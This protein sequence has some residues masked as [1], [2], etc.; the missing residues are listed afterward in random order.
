MAWLFYI[1]LLV[2]ALLGVLVNIV[3]LP[4]LWLIVAAVAGY[5]WATGWNV[6]VGWP[7]LI[8]LIVLALCGELI[9]F[10]ATTRG[11]QKA[12]GRKRGAIGAI[13]GAIV[14]GIFLT[15][16]F[17]IIGTI[18]GVCLGAFIGAAIFEFW[19][20]DISHSLR[21]GAGA[22]KGRFVGIMTKLAFGCVML[23]VTA[24]AAFP[25]ADRASTSAA[26]SSSDTM[27]PLPSSAPTTDPTTTPAP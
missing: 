12:G 1:L 4:G 15:I 5:A 27:I 26:M 3:T 7:S 14:G 11:S 10:L 21:V 20:K 23:I 19:D 17:P 9:E 13:I 18:V 8:T 25:I 2:I 22:A 24:I 16:P 6:F